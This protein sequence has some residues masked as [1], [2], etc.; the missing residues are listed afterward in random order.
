MN[1]IKK[2]INILVVE[3]DHDLREVVAEWLSLPGVN[4]FQ[5]EN[6]KEALKVIEANANNIDMVVSDIKM[7]YVDGM[8]LLKIIRQKNSTI[9]VVLLTTG[10][11]SVTEAEAKAS[12]AIGLLPKPF[13]IETLVELVKSVVNSPAA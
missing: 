3:D 8:E 7:P 9:P 5:A 10:E 13:E 12:G 6:G 2:N 1:I 4:V 11:S